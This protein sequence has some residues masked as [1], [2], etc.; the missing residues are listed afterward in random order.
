MRISA[1]PHMCAAPRWL[2]LCGLVTVVCGQLC[3]FDSK[4]GA[5]Y[6]L[7][8]LVRRGDEP[9]YTV[10][11][12]DIPCTPQVEQNYTYTFNVC[13]QVSGDI[14]K[15]CASAAGAAALQIDKKATYI[16]TD[17]YVSCF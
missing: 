1:S 17:D 13:N 5:T 10:T 12:G 15:A 14:P 8:D 3:V 6:N 11:D 4:M 2:V 16:E 9:S 7:E